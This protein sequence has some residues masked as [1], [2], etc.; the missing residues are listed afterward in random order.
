MYYLTI[1]E[2]FVCLKFQKSANLPTYLLSFGQLPT[3]TVELESTSRNPSSPDIIYIYRY[4][5][6]SVVSKPHIPQQAS[7][8]CYV[9]L[10]LVVQ[11]DVRHSPSWSLVNAKA[12]FSYTCCHTKLAFFVEEDSG[13]RKKEL[14]KLLS[15]ASP[16][17]SQAPSQSSLAFLQSSYIQNTTTSLLPFFY[18]FFLMDQ[19]MYSSIDQLSSSQSFFYLVQY[20]IDTQ[21]VS[22][23]RPLSCRISVSIVVN[24]KRRNLVSLFLFW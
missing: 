20:Y 22:T 2:K 1:G 15:T 19:N 9:V 12:F 7:A 5:Q 14:P 4:I 24:Q 8:L 21:Y 10:V 3:Y 17:I 13:V 11:Y 23:D 18:F 16:H 6:H